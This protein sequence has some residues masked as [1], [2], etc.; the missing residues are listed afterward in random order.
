MKWCYQ[1]SD[2]WEAQNQSFSDRWPVKHWRGLTLLLIL[3][4]IAA[5]TIAQEPPK[6]LVQE[7]T[8]QIRTRTL[9]R[10]VLQVGSQGVEV[11][12]LQ[13][14]LKLLGYYDGAVDGE[15]SEQT[16]EAVSAFQKAAGLTANG[17]VDQ[18]TWNRL[19]PPNPVS[20]EPTP[21]Q[22]CACPQSDTTT[23]TET[24][25]SNPPGFP[26]LQLGMRGDA[27]RGLQGLL[28]TQGF[29][30]SSPDGVFGSSTEAAVIAA[31]TEYQ[32]EPDGIV[33]TQTWLALMGS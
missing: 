16:A 21:A 2:I 11:S 9:Q 19:F 6:T 18:Q 1:N 24:D 13:A 15:Y 32:L 26:I 23:A 33:G 22:N 3:T 29:L 30:Q 28:R 27:V 8:E 4:T 5:P 10:P 25:A 12:E 31:Q 17:I 14:A 7:S 20:A